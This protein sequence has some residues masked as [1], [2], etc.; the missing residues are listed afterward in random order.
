VSALTRVQEDF[1]EHLLRGSQAVLA[2]LSDGGR[3]PAATRLGIYAG[4]YGARLAEALASNYSALAKLLDEDFRALAAAYV[5][6]HD[7]GFRSIR[8][9][10]HELP[11]FL[12]SHPDYAAAPLLAELARF[13]W[14]MGEVFDAAD[15]TPVG[16][17]AL[18]QL[19]PERWAQLRFRFHPSLRRLDL[20]WNAPQVWQALSEPAS[21][22]AAQVSDVPTPW[23]LWRAG[24]SSYFRSLTAAEAVTLDAAVSGWPFGELCELLCEQVGAEAAPA[25]AATYLRTWVEAG[26]IVHAA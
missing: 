12:A 15:A 5:R 19:A 8:Y 20:H 9:Y 17:P 11:Q 22:P 21:R 10:G 23:L 3:V 13:E 2:H 25:Q 1:Q 6:A 18:S 26:L 7:S 14:A 4:A 16:A 24:L